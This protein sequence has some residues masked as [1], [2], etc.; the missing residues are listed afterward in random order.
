MRSRG[1]VRSGGG[2]GQFIFMSMVLATVLAAT[3]AVGLFVG[4]LVTRPTITAAADEPARK[5]AGRRSALAESPV[6]H[7][8]RVE[9]KLTFYQTLTA[10]PSAAAPASKPPAPRPAPERASQR[11]ED[12][13]PPGQPAAL[14]PA[15]ERSPS[16]V[17]RP[18]EPALRWTVQVGAFRNRRQ[19][20]SVQRDLEGAGFEAFTSPNG[21]GEGQVQYRV[22]VG[23]FGSRADAD[24]LASRLRA[25]RSLTPFVTSN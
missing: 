14:P 12:R 7:G 8:P 10:P 4:R 21:A 11:A 1:R 9:D 23:N 6:D 13:S 24:R 18:V 3:F 15:G 2:T 20:E 16:A 17:S 25:E 22:R 19:A 5:P